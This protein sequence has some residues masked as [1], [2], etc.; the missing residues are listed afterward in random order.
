MT[1]KY[2]PRIL[3]RTQFGNPI[4][5]SKTKR[6][7]KDEIKSEEIQNL[8]QDMLHTCEKKKF[9]VGLA[10]TQVG[11][12]VAVSVIQIKRTPTR[13]EAEEYVRV[14]INPEVVETYGNRTGMWEGCISFSAINA[15]VFAKAMRYKKIK[16]RYMDE[17][18]ALHTELLEGLPAHVF[19][20]E[21]DHCDGTLFVDRV[22]D[23]TTWM[24]ATEYKKM[25]RQQR[26]A[27]KVE[28]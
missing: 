22:K 25:V 23:S 10:A 11:V 27:G 2:Q 16:A 28:R 3:R 1:Q 18:G 9:G 19:Q 17:H 12:P 21:T 5:R 6:L 7:T 8:I 4:L 20:H 26:K 13:P 15:P 14:I 24:N